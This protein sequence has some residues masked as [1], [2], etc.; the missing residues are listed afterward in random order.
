M[1]VV[2]GGGRRPAL[3]LGLVGVSSAIGWLEDAAN[4]RRVGVVWRYTNMPTHVLGGLSSIFWSD[5]DGLAVHGLHPQSVRRM[6]DAGY[7]SAIAVV[8]T[9]VRIPGDSR[10]VARSMSVAVGWGASKQWRKVKN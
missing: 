9:I 7:R 1:E 4:P 2:G 3:G 6:P 10:A 8:T 5:E